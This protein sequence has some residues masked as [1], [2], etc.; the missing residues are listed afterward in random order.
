MVASSTVEGHC[1]KDTNRDIQIVAILLRQYWHSFSTPPNYLA[2]AGWGACGA[3]VLGLEKF[4]FGAWRAP[5]D[6]VK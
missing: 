3:D 6:A 5:S 1:E 4:T 2:G